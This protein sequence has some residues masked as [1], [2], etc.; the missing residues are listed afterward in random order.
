MSDKYWVTLDNS[1]KYDDWDVES[2]ND[3]LATCNNEKKANLI[4][5]TLNAM[6]RIKEEINASQS[7]CADD[8]CGH[9]QVI[10]DLIGELKGIK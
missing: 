5:D 6:E 4:R 1:G 10:S 7:T 3:L 9:I 8:M 2:D